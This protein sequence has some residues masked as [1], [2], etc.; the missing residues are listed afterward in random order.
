[1]ADL[2]GVVLGVGASNQ[3]AQVVQVAALP[4][5]PAGVHDPAS[6]LLDILM[7]A[8]QVLLGL[9]LSPADGLQH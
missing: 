2:V 5:L 1:M 6:C 3:A 4:W 9:R 7:T 8:A